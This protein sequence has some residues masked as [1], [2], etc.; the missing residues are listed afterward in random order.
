MTNT[1]IAFGS[2]LGDVEATY[3]KA[4]KLLKEGGFQILKKSAL[5]ANKAVNCLPGTPDFQNGAIT[6]KWDSDAKELLSLCQKIE[7]KLGRPKA[8]QS[9][10]SRMIDLDIIL[11]GNEIIKTESLTVPHPRAQ[12]RGF[13]LIPLNQIAP[14]WIFPDSKLTVSEDLEKL[15]R[16]AE[17]K[18]I[19]D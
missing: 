3:N 14:D 6:G 15:E 9:N 7:V 18:P 8:H 10:M 11:F 19:I 5:L 13:V 1:A 16:S 2:N 12:S 17:K 4:I